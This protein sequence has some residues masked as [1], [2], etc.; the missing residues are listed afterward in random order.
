MFTSNGRTNYTRL[1]QEHNHN[2]NRGNLDRS[3]LPRG[4][5]TKMVMSFKAGNN[6]RFAETLVAISIY[7]NA[8]T[9]DAQVAPDIASTASA[10]ATPTLNL[11]VPV[12]PGGTPPL[13]SHPPSVGPFEQEVTYSITAELSFR[14]GR[15]SFTE[16]RPF[17][18]GRL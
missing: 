10:S 13:A 9:A 8:F 6:L 18:A 17:V 4:S 5:Q 1:S 11:G 15:L 12:M 14:N 2:G 16:V 3:S 7:A